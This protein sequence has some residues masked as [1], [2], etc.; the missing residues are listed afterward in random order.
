VQTHYNYCG[1]DGIIGKKSKMSFCPSSKRPNES[2]ME[3]DTVQFGASIVPG[4]RERG[5]LAADASPLGI[6]TIFE[7]LSVW[8]F[9]PFL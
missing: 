5:G 2:A 7:S 6:E 8:V 9:S 1:I 4:S 3:F